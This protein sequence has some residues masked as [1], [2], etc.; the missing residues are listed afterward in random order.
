MSAKPPGDV[1]ALKDLALVD[2]ARRD[3]ADPGMM[4][5]EYSEGGLEDQG[6]GT[7]VRSEG[8]TEA[9]LFPNWPDLEGRDGFN[10][11]ESEDG[12]EAG[13]TESSV[14]QNSVPTEGKVNQGLQRAYWSPT[15]GTTPAEDRVSVNR[16]HWNK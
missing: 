4:D 13:P 10:Q 2:E 8:G 14:A 12:P 11:S 9:E 5:L 16:G 3:F 6:R 1:E 15:A 7:D